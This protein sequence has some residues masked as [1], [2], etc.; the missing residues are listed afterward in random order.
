[1]SPTHACIF[2]RTVP[3]P[4]EVIGCG[5]V[6]V[7]VGVL[8]LVPGQAV[9][10]AEG[11]VAEVVAGGGSLLHHVPVGLAPIL[12]VAVLHRP[13][14][15]PARGRGVVRARRLG[16][17]GHRR[18]RV[19]AAEVTAAAADAGRLRAA[20]VVADAPGRRAAL[21][22]L[23]PVEVIGRV[24]GGDVDRGRRPADG[25]Q[26]VVRRL[27]GLV[28][29]GGVEV[30]PSDDVFLARL[31]DLDDAGHDEEDEHQPAGHG[32]DGQVGVVQAVQDAGFTLLC[33]T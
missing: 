16:R 9:L 22:L 26:L 18:H 32:D 23:E 21:E 14:A 15:A 24:V 12:R 2:D 3:L 27:Q 6:Q 25:A 5:S 4:S 28:E 31:F 19:T 8:V 1:M 11:V 17:R 33:G 20:V 7:G 30:I 13:G 10:V 29:Q